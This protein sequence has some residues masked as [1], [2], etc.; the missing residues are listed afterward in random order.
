M[1]MI[2]TIE[3]LEQIYGSFDAIGEASTA[4]VADR[5]TPSYRR[6]ID[7]SPF[8]ALATM[9]PEGLDCSPRGDLPGFVRVHDDKTLMLPDR[10]GNNRVDSLR[11]I[12]RDPRIALLFLIPGAGTTLR[13]NGVACVSAEPALLESFKVDGK[14]PRTVVVTG[15]PT[16]PSVIGTCQV[17]GLFDAASRPKRP[18][19]ST[20]LVTPFSQRAPVK[21]T[22]D[23]PPC[24][25]KSCATCAT[26]FPAA[27]RQHQVATQRE[28]GARPRGHAVDRS[29]NRHR[30]R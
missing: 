22:S 18:C 28:V 16:T 13:V 1:T 8:V 27:G 26:G 19:V 10:R 20:A 6:L 30:H 17:C 23:T 25:V 24:K 2:T 7:V 21:V 9:G 11:N 29:Q 14:A 12:V 5:V 15:L 4:K 3:Q